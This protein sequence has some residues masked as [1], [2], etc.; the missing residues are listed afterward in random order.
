MPNN[1]PAR[2]GKQA[3]VKG[4]KAKE[5]KE[6]DTSSLPKEDEASADGGTLSLSSAGQD[7]ATSASIMERT[8]VAALAMWHEQKAKP[9]EG[10][11]L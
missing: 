2:R 11:L 1:S 4:K 6:T 7:Q 5:S 8:V 10:K 9:K 3:K